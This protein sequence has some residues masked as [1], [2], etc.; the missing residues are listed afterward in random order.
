MRAPRHQ[1]SM[2]R[3]RSKS[4]VALLAFLLASGSLTLS[5]AGQTAAVAA[6][7]DQFTV[8]RLGILY[9]AQSTRGSSYTGTL[10]NVVES[11]VREL[12]QTGGG[13]VVFT[14][15][16]FDYGADYGDFS[17]ISDIEFAGQ[18]MDATVIQ[19]FATASADTEPFNMKGSTRV[20]IRDMTVSGGGSFRSTSDA[21]DFDRGNDVRVER[22]K[23]TA[24]RGRGIVFDG[25]GKGWTADRNIVRSCVVTGVPSDG[26]ELLASNQ[27][28]I[29]GCTI[30]HVGGH[31]IQITKSS[32][33]AQQRN[34]KSNDNVLLG[35]VIDQ[36]G[37]DGINISSSDRNVIDGNT[38]TNSSDD[39]TSR[40]GIRI[41]SFDGIT[42]DDNVV[43]N[44]RATDTQ[45]PKTQ[46][47]GLHIASAL[48]HRTVVGP[49]NDFN[50]N[51]L[52]PIR[53]AG[54]NSELSA[55]KTGPGPG[56]GTKAPMTRIRR[57]AQGKTFGAA[58]IRSF[59]G[60][61]TDTGSGLS[62]VEVALR[63]KLASGCKWWN[64]KRFVRG[65]CRKKR[66]QPAAGLASWTYA[67]PRTLR[68]SDGG[69]IRYYTVYSRGTDAAGRTESIFDRGR[70]VNRFEVT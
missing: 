17:G 39:V 51:A 55:Q 66:F 70:N 60:T 62:L 11:A 56:A 3:T 59:R 24:S 10:K 69:K 45:T 40:D 2:Q 27:N 43:K 64:G 67:L 68:P 58:R 33:L 4:V 37:Q 35:N 30:T 28:R 53:D 23:I 29:E 22:V 1:R 15:G 47:Y 46:K 21:I 13:R 57:P 12:N 8:S 31:G 38:V 6:A 48:C 9:R 54:K 42:C 26:I 34:K 44:S 32:P 18:G 16:V 61:A 7:G 41:T 5:R 63:Q 65:G 25:K 52:G 19:N 50:G 49:N 20:V 36:S 14:A